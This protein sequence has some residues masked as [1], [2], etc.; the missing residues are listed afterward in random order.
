MDEHPEERGD[1]RDLLRSDGI[2]ISIIACPYITSALVEP[3]IQYCKYSFISTLSN[4]EAYMSNRVMVSRW[5]L[6]CISL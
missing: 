2:S 4:V 1:L 6:C 5:F 3:L